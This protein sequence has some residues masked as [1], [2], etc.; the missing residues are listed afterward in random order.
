[1]VEI[2]DLQGKVIY[3]HEGDTLIQINLSGIDLSHADLRNTDL[4]GSN[5][6]CA[7]LRYADLRGAN[8]CN[9]DL[10]NALLCHADLCNANLHGA[11]LSRGDLYWVNLSCADLSCA[12]L[13][14]AVLNYAYLYDANLNHANLSLTHLYKAD[15]RNTDLSYTNFCNAELFGTNLSWAI[16]KGANLRY[17]RLDH[18]CLIDIIMDET[19]KGLNDKCPKEG[20]FIGYKKCFNFQFTRNYIVELEILSDAKRSSSTTHKCRC[21]KAKVLSITNID[22]SKTNVKEVYSCFNPNF[23]Y[24]LGKIVEEPNFDDKYWNE[25]SRGIHFFMD[26][27]DAV[28]Y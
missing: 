2:K 11:N 6:R 23:K 14:Q 13:T 27:K 25:C 26:R 1:M 7:D 22:G 4:H 18:A 10:S 15:L 3:T 20:S 21:N 19:T 24:T 12:N 5:L 9:V 8:L 16:L 28:G 17:T